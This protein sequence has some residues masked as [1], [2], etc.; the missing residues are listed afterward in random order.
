MRSLCFFS[1]NRS[2][3]GLVRPLLRAVR[4]RP[5]LSS[6]LILSGAHV[7]GDFGATATEVESTLVDRL[8]PVPL[9]VPLDGSLAS[10]VSGYAELTGKAGE[11]LLRLR[12][13][14]LVILGDRAESLA[15]AAVAHLA[16]IAIAHLYGGDLSQGGQW[17]DNNRHALTKLAHLHFVSNPDS[18]RRVLGLGEEPWRVHE[19][20]ATSVDNFLEGEYTPEG[21]L[22]EKYGLKSGEPFILFTQHPVSSQSDQAFAQAMESLAA[23]VTLGVPTIITYPCQDLGAD[24]ILRAIDCHRQESH[25]RIHPSLGWRDYVGLLH[26]HPVVV[27]NSSSGLLETPIVKCPCVNIGSRQ[28]GRLRAG[29]VLDVGHDRE[30]IAAAVRRALFDPEVAARVR[31]VRNPYGEGGASRKIAEVLA[32]VPRDRRLL[33]K[34]MTY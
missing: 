10:V 11:I 3:Y 2:E 29:N 13:D 15:V 4:E 6:C 27:G 25:F 19:F 12:P 32:M 30:A 9:T 22:R 31:A 33:T 8:I 21:E 5:D 14:F 34:K 20:G 7:S 1:G 16:N 28:E 23:L 17:D 18:A 24:G 26:L